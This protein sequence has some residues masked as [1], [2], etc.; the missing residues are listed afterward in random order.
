MSD[1]GKPRMAF[2]GKLG[3]WFSARR[4]ARALARRR[5]QALNRGEFFQQLES[6]ELL[7]SF[8]LVGST[9][10]LNLDQASQKVT[11]TS[12]SSGAAYK[13]VLSGGANNTW[14]GTA[15]SGLTFSTA[16][17]NAA[18]LTAFS[19]VNITDSAS[20]V[21]VSF[22]TGAASTYSDN[23]D[24]TL[25]NSANTSGAVV[26][27][28][29][30]TANF[31]GSSALAITAD[32]P[33]K[34]NSGATLTLAN[35]NVGIT[36]N[37]PS[38]GSFSESG[39]TINN[40]TLQTTGTGLTTINAN[41]G[42]GA[43]ASYQNKGVSVH[44][45]GRIIGGTTGTMSITGRSFNGVDGTLQ[46]QGVFLF[47]A[48]GANT[49]TISSNG[50]NVSITGYGANST[51]ATLS[52]F[53][54]CMVNAGVVIGGPGTLSGTQGGLITSGGNGAVTVTGYGGSLANQTSANN[55][56]AMGVFLAGSNATIS[57]GGAGL[58]T[59]NGTG[60]GAQ[61]NTACGMGVN[62]NQGQITSGTNGSVSV[63]GTGC[64]T[65]CSSYNHGVVLQG[66]TGLIAA[67]TGTG[68]TT[69]VGT[70]GGCGT[71][72]I[73]EGVFVISN[74]TISALGSGNVSV[75][76]SGGTVS[77]NTNRGVLLSSSGLIT[78]N[79]GAV[80]VTGTGGGS[81]S[82]MNNHGV[83]LITNGTITAG[84]T[85]NVTVRGY[86]GNNNGTGN[87]NH[88]VSVDSGGS[89]QAPGAITSGGGHVD[90]RGTGGGGTADSPV[91]SASATN[92]GVFVNQ[93]GYIT[94]G[95]SGT[96][97]VFGQGGGR[98]PGATGS[99]NAGVCITT[100][101]TTSANTAAFSC[102][103]SGG[104]AVSVTG[105]GGGGAAGSG[106]SGS[107]NYGV[108][109]TNGGQLTTGG[110][111]S[112]TVNGT[113]GG[114]GNG[115]TA[116]NYGVFANGTQL[117]SSNSTYVRAT[118]STGGSGNL[119]INGTGG[120]S[121]GSGSSNY[122][123]GV[124]GGALITAGGATSA[125]TLSGQGGGLSAQQNYG[126]QITGGNATV[127]N[128]TVTSG[129]GN[130][131]VTGCGPLNSSG[132]NQHGVV[133]GSNGI[134]SSGG[135]GSVTVTGTGGTGDVGTS[136]NGHV[137]VQVSGATLTSG[138]IGAVLVT[139]TGG[140]SGARV[141]NYGVQV[142]SAGVISGGTGAS[143]TVL[144]T[145]GNANGSG[146]TNYETSR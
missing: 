57:S 93:G 126:V 61:A 95:G 99:S 21:S 54:A 87:T 43:A 136:G 105:I 120:G 75:S 91:A 37:T 110:S 82:S 19:A 143:V 92:H 78:S 5:H 42:I 24:I 39:L 12:E 132:S 2:H 65:A 116:S 28:T 17:L 59:V 53:G 117:V 44:T 100:A 80:L 45:G 131:S 18:N 10:N 70:G 66:A 134:L 139:G 103:S 86:G 69:V 48:G 74:G 68:T 140:G 13:F 55:A 26:V 81:G 31:T 138:G 97:T 122:G 11:I 32:G 76:G 64:T 27:D 71:A 108:A 129:G 123:I 88:G 63:T 15:G 109:V 101:N 89:G 124:A 135:N 16:T 50:A 90:V 141:G 79:G 67:G 73:N 8:S 111:A 107:T 33:V 72:S 6:R 52:G 98:S 133:L 104:G 22:G 146:G 4:Q 60:G 51:C 127:G 77:G 113:G 125:V 9:L 102:I 130:V 83:A 145:G 49:S 94:A 128:S 142:N 62:L 41:G 34:L 46:G 20:G 1:P 29:N 144:G 30:V 14:T 112:L 47:N 115:T 23:F 84:S 114:F 7:T 36:V 58:V 3:G 96:V 56:Y 137:G 40:A 85:A 119:I 118:I 38:G 25:D 106:A 35:G 121:A